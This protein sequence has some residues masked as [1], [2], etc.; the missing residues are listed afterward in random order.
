MPLKLPVRLPDPTQSLRILRERAALVS[1]RSLARAIATAVSTEIDRG[2]GFILIPVFLALGAIAYFSLAYEP[3]FAALAAASL[4]LTTIAILAR[5][6]PVLHLAACAAVLFLLG[7]VVAKL[8]SHRAATKVVGSEISTLLTGDVAAIEHMADGRVRLSIDVTGTERP[9]LRYAPDRVRV[10]ARRVPDG[11]QPGAAVTGLV[12][13]MPPSGPVRPDSY[14]FSFESYF[15]GIGASGFF[16]RD[17]QRAEQSG[18]SP[19]VARFFA[20]V[21]RARNGV[22]DR[23]RS[24][25]PGAEGEIAA[26]L[27]VGVRAGIPQDVNDALRRA[28]LYHIISISG[29]HMALVA[30]TIMGCLRGGFALFPQFSSRRP[31]KK[32]A[33]VVALFGLAAYL[34]FSGADVAAQRSFIML[35]VMLAALLFD[36]AALTMRNLAISAVVVIFISPHEVTGPSFQMSFA[37][38]AALVGAYAGWSDYRSRR[39][40]QPPPGRSLGRSA[41]RKALVFATGLAATSLVAGGATSIYSALHFQQVSSLGLLANLTA[42]PIVSAVVMPSAVFGTLAMPFGLDGYCFEIMGIGLSATVAIARWFA[43]RSPLD[44]IGLVSPT[45]VVVLTI[46]LLIAT[47]CTTWLRAAALPVALAGLLSLG[48]QSPPDLLISEDARL[49]GMALGN[50]QLAANR[51]RPN[52]FTVDNWTR[53]LQAK[54]IVKPDARNAKSAT[55]LEASLAAS[56]GKAD[57]LKTSSD[58]GATSAG[59]VCEDGLCLATHPSGAIVAHAA[60]LA[61]ARRACVEASVIVIDDATA[62]DICAN[63]RILVVTKRDLARRGS[64]S[65]TFADKTLNRHNSGLRTSN[66]IPAT[67]SY[68]IGAPYR[69]WHT[70]R[71]FSREARGMPPYQREAPTRSPPAAP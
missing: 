70:Q 51:A 13:L 52:E 25:I 6:L 24:R 53:A 44:I 45:G 9:V 33:A 48:Q 67:I 21:E 28:G 47:T 32:Y 64:A 2:T 27:V 20:A 56:H 23:I 60:N 65:V 10:S 55:A 12:R 58:E 57:V 17:P 71:R 5:P 1:R 38:T 62:R 37:A 54:T 50:G 31:V 42:M 19:P 66:Y 43:E 22:A 35:A 26:A 46:A 69:P 4:G 18:P 63:P 29:L 59:F 15:D 41:L 14:D 34:F 36:R 7:V 40:I 11:L 61:S 39:P 8:E 49:V 3:G 30:A 16:L 68:A